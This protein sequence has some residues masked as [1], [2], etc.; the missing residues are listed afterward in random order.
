MKCIPMCGSRELIPLKDEEKEP[1]EKAKE[2]L[3][4]AIEEFNEEEVNK[5]IFNGNCL[6][7]KLNS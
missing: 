3:R 1:F 6:F 7:A 2:N 5:I 4:K